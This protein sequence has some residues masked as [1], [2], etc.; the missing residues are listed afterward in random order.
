MTEPKGR[1]GA[2]GANGAEPERKVASGTRS[3]V[4]G[5][6]PNQRG[7]QPFSSADGAGRDAEARL[8]EAVGLARAI[9]LTV[10]ADLA[11]NLG[12]IRPA[13]FLGKGKVEEIAGL[14]AAAEVN[15]RRP[16]RDP[17]VPSRVSE[18]NSSPTA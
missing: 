18:P 4:V 6:Y 3:F 12:A 16:P 17:E 5:P 15:S 9:D 2:L 11:V 10:I 13:T 8:E 7:H 14:V 1:K